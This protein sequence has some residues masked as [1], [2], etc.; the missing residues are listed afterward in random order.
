LRNKKRL[1]ATYQEQLSA[2]VKIVEDHSE[3]LSKKVKNAVENLKEFESIE[4]E[5]MQHT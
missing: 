3:K 2:F 1:C 5:L 4:Q